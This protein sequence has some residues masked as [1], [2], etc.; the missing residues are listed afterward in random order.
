MVFTVEILC[1]LAGMTPLIAG[2]IQSGLPMVAIGCFV[3]GLIWIL[4]E[5]NRLAWVAPAGLFILITIT[6]I[7]VWMGLSP[8]LMAMSVLG[9]LLAWDLADFSRRLR[10]ADQEDELRSLKR[11]HLV[12]LA[13]L[14]AISLVLILAAL[15]IHLQISFGWLFLLSLAAV[16]GIMQLIKRLRLGGK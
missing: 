3:F 4:A 8:F 10:E 6:G 16:L 11:N 15:L 7:G 5:W 1:I 2:Y 9:T 13:G 14:A 12:R